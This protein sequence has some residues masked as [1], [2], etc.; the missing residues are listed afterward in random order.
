LREIVTNFAAQWGLDPGVEYLNHGSFGACPKAV[1]AEQR[2]KVDL[3][4]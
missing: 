3:R 4:A 2:N 1:L